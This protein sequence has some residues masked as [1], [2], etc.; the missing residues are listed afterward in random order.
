MT[1]SNALAKEIT[2]LLIKEKRRDRLWRNLRFLFIMS[3]IAFLIITA[4]GSKK[5]TRHVKAGKP[6]LALVRLNGVIMDGAGISARK[7]NKEITQAFLD[8]NAAGVVL[9]INSPG[10]SPVQATLIHDKIL[11]LK[12]TKVHKFITETSTVLE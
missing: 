2:E 6:Y 9:V 8:K 7:A 10:G 4:D 12:E 5:T 1:E 11:E 3:L